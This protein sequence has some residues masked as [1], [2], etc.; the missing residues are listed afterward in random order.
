M[1]ELVPDFEN[2]NLRGARV[3]GGRLLLIVWYTRLEWS[4]GTTHE[5]GEGMD[6][7]RRAIENPKLPIQHVEPVVVSEGQNA[8]N[9]L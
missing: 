8:L 5:F 4:L 2:L 6:M 7:W 9:R 3:E 1:R